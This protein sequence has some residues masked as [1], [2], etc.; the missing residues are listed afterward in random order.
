MLVRAIF[1]PAFLLYTAPLLAQNGADLKAPSVFTDL[2]N[3]KSIENAQERLACYDQKVD[4]LDKAQQNE[5]IIV[6]D[7]EAV[8]DAKKGLFGFSLPKL[9]IF[10]KEGDTQ[11]E[12]LVST[13]KSAHQDRSGKWTFVLED[14]AEWQQID[15]E[16]PRRDPKAGM[17][18]KIRKASLGSYFVN[19][20]GRRAIRMRR[21]G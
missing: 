20:E 15:S 21:I 10:G 12:E 3:C 6:T 5:D 11:L 18:V 13:I 1:M 4:S 19:V 2:I 17:E 9:K 14:G 8:Q 16:I 7:K